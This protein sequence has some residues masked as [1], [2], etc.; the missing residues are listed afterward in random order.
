MKSILEAIFIKLGRYIIDAL[1]S[2]EIRGDA[3]IIAMT[4]MA[5]SHLCLAHGAQE[6]LLLAA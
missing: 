2:M 3:D 5:K 6:A 4:I 1:A